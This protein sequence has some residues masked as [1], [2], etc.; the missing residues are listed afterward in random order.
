D[1]T[2]HKTIYKNGITY[3]VKGVIDFYNKTEHKIIEIKASNMDS[4][5]KEWIMQCYMYCMIKGVNKFSIANICQGV[6]YNYDIFKSYDMI[7]QSVI[8]SQLLKRLFIHDFI[9]NGF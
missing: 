7:Q 3:G 1:K 4:V 8:K 5:R 9:I 6:L 2:I